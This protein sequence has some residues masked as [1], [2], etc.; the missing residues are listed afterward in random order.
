MQADLTWD[1]LL[2]WEGKNHRC[3]SFKLIEGNCQKGTAKG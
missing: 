2:P 3:K 1:Y